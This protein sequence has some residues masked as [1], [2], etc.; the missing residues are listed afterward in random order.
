MI[1]KS[2]IDDVPGVPQTIG[3]NVGEW[4]QIYASYIYT[5]G[6]VGETVVYV[7]GVVAGGITFTLAAHGPSVFGGADTFSIG[8]GLIGKVR[9]IQIYSPATLQLVQSKSF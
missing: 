9:R 3:I 4:T 2:Q 8:S 7:N 6:G 5:Y 1:L